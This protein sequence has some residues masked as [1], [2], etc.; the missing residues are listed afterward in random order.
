MFCITTMNN[1]F[2]KTL[3][4]L[5]CTVLIGQTMLTG[6]V[7]AS[8]I[9]PSEVSKSISVSS[10][11]HSTSATKEVNKSVTDVKIVTNS[12]NKLSNDVK[13]IG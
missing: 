7:S 3:A 12:E 9:N 8:E 2:K 11:A 4:L 10:S 5:A 13:V 1:I 6:V